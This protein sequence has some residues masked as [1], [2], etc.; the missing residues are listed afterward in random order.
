MT[1][2]GSLRGGLATRAEHCKETFFPALCPRYTQMT[3]LGKAACE[4]PP[5]AVIPAVGTYQP[6]I[7][8]IINLHLQRSSQHRLW[9]GN[10]SPGLFHC[11]R[12]VQI[13]SGSLGFLEE[14]TGAR[15]AM[16]GWGGLRFDSAQHSVSTCI[17]L[18]T[19]SWYVYKG[20]WSLAGSMMGTGSF[21]SGIDQEMEPLASG[22][23]C[24]IH[25]SVE[26]MVP[27]SVPPP[28]LPK[29]QKDE[30]QQMEQRLMLPSS[31]LFKAGLSSGS[32]VQTMF[33]DNNLKHKESKSQWILPEVIHFSG[34]N[35]RGEGRT[36][37]EA[38]L[39]QSSFSCLSYRQN[40][41][42]GHFTG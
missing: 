25:A 4:A 20:L 11:V 40:H 14:G 39:T 30:T 10:W 21:C 42:Y 26:E 6:L 12:R 41:R 23:C 29:L 31:F 2:T 22:N 9:S 28:R 27:P 33:L 17:P 3:S 18:H 8:K 35:L 32:M 34:L 16:H 5:P 37:C 19:G 24:F 1:G 38:T 13:N 15:E 7:T 36:N